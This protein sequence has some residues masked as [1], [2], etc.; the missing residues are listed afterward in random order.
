MDRSPASIL[1]ETSIALQGGLRWEN[2]WGEG[3]GHIWSSHPARMGVIQRFGDVSGGNV[4]FGALLSEEEWA[5]AENLQF[6]APTPLNTTKEELLRA[7]YF[8]QLDQP[9]ACWGGPDLSVQPFNLIIK[10]K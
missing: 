6:Q 4:G 1:L 8:Y 10:K 2:V 5:Q 3:G 7:L 9:L